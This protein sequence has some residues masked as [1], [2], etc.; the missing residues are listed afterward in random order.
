MHEDLPAVVRDAFDAMEKQLRKLVE[1]QQGE[2]KHHEQQEAVAIVEK[3]FPDE[4]Y[5]FLKTVEGR[6]VY[7]HRNAVL[8]NDFD[9][10][11]PGTGVNLMVEMGEKGLQATSVRIVD[12]PGERR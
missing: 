2:T 7:F 11:T 12:K 9:R 3:L 4:N 1:K 10:L 8:H 5:G 6:D